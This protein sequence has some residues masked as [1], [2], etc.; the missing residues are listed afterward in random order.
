MIKKVYFKVKRKIINFL[1]KRLTFLY[2]PSSQPYISGDTFRKISD[3]VY[4]ESKKLLPQKVKNNDIVFLKTDL[5]QDYFQNVNSKIDAKY[6]LISHNSDMEIGQRELEM[7]DENIIFWFAQNLSVEN[8]KNYTL[9]PIGLEN[10]RYQING[11]LKNFDIQHPKTK[12]NKIAS[13]FNISTNVKVRSKLKEIIDQNKNV[14]SVDSDNHRDY[15][16][17]LKDFMFNLCPVGNGL[18]THRI[19]ES[20]LVKTI[21]V[22]EDSVFTKNLASLNFPILVLESWQ[23]LND[24]SSEDLENIYKDEAEKKQFDEVVKLEYWINFIN[25][26]KIVC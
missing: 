16:L 1:I 9:L 20:L 22:M 8:T 5:I 15:I 18:D 10:L 24:L 3:H 6:I 7:I 2:R 21:P 17:N 25:R 12:K 19:W 23:D 14:E 4:D 11:V 13:S 26:K